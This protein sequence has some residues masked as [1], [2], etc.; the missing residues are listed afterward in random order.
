[1]NT[2]SLKEIAAEVRWQLKRD[3]PLWKFSVQVRR[4]EAIDLTL[5]AGPAHVLA[6]S[7]IGHAQ[8]NHYAFLGKD[9][10]KADRLISN[11][12]IL[13][14][15]GWDVMSK[16]THILAAYHWDK[17][18]IQADYFNCN[19]YIHVNIGKWDRPF[20]VRGISR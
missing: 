12:Y 2:L 11:G 10:P 8:L 14:S 16:A 1:M 20:E 18:D 9:F 17:S 5:M 19:F 13:T 15:K 4:Y 3:L 6:D 7:T